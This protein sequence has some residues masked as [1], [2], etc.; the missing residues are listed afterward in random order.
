MLRLAQKGKIHYLESAALRDCGFLTHAFLTRWNGASDG[1]FAS[2]NFSSRE[3]D[4]EDR[5]A[6]NWELLGGAFGILPSQF[7]MI[8]QIH[9]DRVV[10]ADGMGEPFSVH[11]PVECDAVITSSRHVAIGIKTADCV[12]ILLADLAR[13]VIGAVHAGWKGTS[14]NIVGK[15]VRVMTE[16]FSSQ[17]E[18]IMAAIGPAVGP[19]CYQV[20]AKVFSASEADEDWTSAFRRCM[21]D[22]RWMLD[23]ALANRK[24]MLRTGLLPENISSLGV[25]TSCRRDLFFSHRAEKGGTGRQLNFIV[26]D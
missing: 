14:L 7:F 13:R 15:S 18:D 26:L 17:P 21:E 25:C 22:G 12:P 10:V 19:C 20:D 1:K 4:G 16:R 23:L 11:S 24:Q 6:R 2:L 9:G 5:V 8:R 3:G